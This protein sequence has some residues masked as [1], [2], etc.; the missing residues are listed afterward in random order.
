MVRSLLCKASLEVSK[1]KDLRR[2]SNAQEQVTTVN[3]HQQTLMIWKLEA[4]FWRSRPEHFHTYP[5]GKVTMNL[6]PENSVPKKNHLPPQ[7]LNPLCLHY[8]P[9]SHHHSTAQASKPAALF[10]SPR[11]CRIFGALHGGYHGRSDIAWCCDLEL[12]PEHAPWW[13]PVNDEGGGII[14]E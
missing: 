7:S 12:F 8:I 10:L 13:Q 4:V 1:T 9:S 14:Q 6:M 11:S 5:T 3:K 2:R